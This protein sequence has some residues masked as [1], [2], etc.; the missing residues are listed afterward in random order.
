M[1]GKVRKLITFFFFSQVLATAGC[2]PAA[3]QEGETLVTAAPANSVLPPDANPATGTVCN[4]FGGG[5][6]GRDQ[7]L[8]GEL[9]YLPD[10]LPKYQN[11]SDYIQN[12]TKIEADLYFDQVNVPTRPFDAGF[13]TTDGQVMKTPAGNTLY[14]WFGIRF[15]SKI[16]LTNQDAIGKYQFALIA[17]DGAVLLEKLPDG[18]TR[19]IV[20]NDGQHATKF[21]VSSQPVVLNGTSELP[22]EVRYYQGPRMHIAAMVMWREWPEGATAYKDPLDGREGNDLFFSSNS[23]PS[24][25]LAA[26]QQLQARG[27]RPVPAANFYLPNEVKANPCPETP[28][29]PEVPVVVVPPTVPSE[30]SVPTVP[31]EPSAPAELVIVGFDATT[32]ANSASLLW[33]TTGASST[34]KVYYGLSADALNQVADLGSIR[35]ENHR[36]TIA[37]LSS[38]TV[39]YFRAESTDASGKTVSSSVIMK[40]TK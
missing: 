5:S 34:T 19:T 36:L 20:N 35:A 31:T 21:K 38:A 15:E 14:E 27:W 26:Y 4:P 1:N 7:G 17:D 10:N 30:P 40:A 32:T 23:V 28:V 33:A 13:I 11:V 3:V 25:P 39:Y 24:T 9:F 8:K 18:S 6:A 37:G 12:G 22:I 2:V 16:R 29:Q